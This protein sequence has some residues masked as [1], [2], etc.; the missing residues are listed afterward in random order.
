MYIR[1]DDKNRILS[2][3]EGK[4]FEIITERMTLRKSGKDYDGRCP[5]CGHEHSLKISPAKQIFKC[6]HCNQLEGNNAVSWLMKAEGMDYPQA[7]KTLAEHFNIILSDPRQRQTQKKAASKKQGKHDTDSY[8]ARILADSGLTFAD[9]TAHV[10]KTGETKTIFEMPAFFKGSIDTRGEITRDG[11]DVIIAYF[12]LEGVPVYYELKDKKGKPTGNFRE[13][14]RVRWKYPDEH[15]DKEG[16]PVKYRTPYGAG[17]P[18]YIPEKIRAAYKASQPIPRLFI[19]EGEKKAEKACKHGIMSIA[20]SGIQNI[21]MHGR[22]PESVINLIQRCHVKEVVFMLDA[23]CFDLSAN[24]KIGE[25]VEKRPRNFF[26]AVRNYKD[27]FRSLR[28]RELYVE[29]LF[30]YILKNEANDKGIDDLLANTLAGKESELVNDIEYAVN[31]KD[32]TGRY[33]Q[34]HKITTYTDHKLQEIWSI[35]NFTAFAEKYKNILKD[36]PEFMIGKHRWRFNDNGELEST[37][38]IEADEQYWK[39]ITRIRAGIESKTYEFHY[40]HCFSFLRNRGFG[41]YLRPAGDFNFIKLDAPFVRTVETWEIRD[42]ITEFTKMIAVEDVLE[43]IYRGGPQY[44]GPDKLNNLQFIQPA[45]ET[46]ERDRH[47]F[48]FKEQ[49]WIISKDTIKELDYTTIQHHIWADL[50][51][52]ITAQR[53]PEPLIRVFRDESGHFSYVITNNGKQSHFLRFL[54]NTSNFTWRKQQLIKEGKPDIVITPDELYDNTLHLIAKLC[55][56]GYMVVGMKDRS[57]A[58]AV[59]AMDGKQSEVGASN[60]RTGKSIIGELLKH[61][62][63]TIYINGKTIDMEDDKFLWDELTEKTRTVFIDDVRPGFNIELLFANITGDWS[64]NYKGGRRC[65]FPFTTSPKIYLTTNHTLRGEGSSFLDRQWVIAFSDFYNDK[66]KPLDDFGIMFFDE[67]DFEQWNITWNLLAECVQLYFRYGCIQSPQE[68]IEIRRLRHHMGEEFLTWAEEYFSADDKLNTRL[69]RKELYD[70]FLEHSP[71]QRKFCSTTAFKTKIQNY[72]TWK[73]YTFNP[74]KYDPVTG[75]PFQTDK[76]GQP[77][78]DDK[79]GG[80]EY[81]T[82]GNDAFASVA[83]DDFDVLAQ[84]VTKK[85]PF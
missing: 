5:K 61:I 64:V 21:G 8:C 10:Y 67:W 84:P 70:A 77:V 76:D 6:F 27:Y 59:V 82:I 60:G 40:G 58:K 49:C 54:E 41:R 15:L 66:H 46:P 83:G 85:P 44:L 47:L 7:L 16:K 72:C 53:L 51:K 52:D 9:V 1:D 73:G 37:Q 71:G 11:D 74:H 31:E 26:Y 20:V 4:L 68:R 39:E 32:H 34:L 56:I 48:Y 28:N 55:A 12:D 42:F 25:P 63:T 80:V 75:I 78:I 23:D 22:L 30:G 45:F 17:T 57:V 19:Q 79:S 36:L 29:I 14:T 65:T 43:M 3:A 35:H 18:I 62:T 33:V 13:F 50:C 2:H 24:L 38:P 69:P 81:F